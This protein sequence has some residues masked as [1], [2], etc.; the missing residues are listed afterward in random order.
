MK[1]LQYIL[2]GEKYN[3]SP[4]LLNKYRYQIL[5]YLVLIIGKK[6]YGKKKCNRIVKKYINFFKY[7][8][9]N[10][11]LD[12]TNEEDAYNQHRELDKTTQDDQHQEVKKKKRKHR[13]VMCKT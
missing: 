13:C 5:C 10:K 3:I 11:F 4:L 6:K 9:I 2:L 12:E 8:F 1:C 7:I